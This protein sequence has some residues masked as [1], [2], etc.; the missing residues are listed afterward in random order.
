MDLIVRH[1]LLFF[2]AYAPFLSLSAETVNL[3][4]NK[5]IVSL[6]FA[7]NDLYLNFV[8]NKSQLHCSPV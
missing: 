7:S 2:L 5:L 1:K 3:H 4:L 6:P 8:P